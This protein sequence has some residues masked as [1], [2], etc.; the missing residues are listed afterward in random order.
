MEAGEKEGRVLAWVHGFIREKVTESKNEISEGIN[1]RIIKEAC[2]V[3]N[4]KDGEEIKRNHT[5][6]M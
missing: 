6:N 1:K 5:P 3:S 2:Q 4:G